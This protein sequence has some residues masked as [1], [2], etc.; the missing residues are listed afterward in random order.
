MRLDG[1][2]EERTRKPKS[3]WINPKYDSGSATTALAKMF[4]EKVF[5]NPK[6][7]AFLQDIF[8]ISTTSN[9]TILD[10]F[11]GSGS[12]GEAVLRLNEQDGGNRKFILVTNNEEKIC[13]DVTY[14]RLKKVIK[15]YKD[16]QDIKVDGVE[17]NLHHLKTEFINKKKYCYFICF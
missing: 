13:E 14:P 1:E 15:G 12:T 17:A 5:D 4:G 6:P 9:S 11:A 8:T 2:D 10:F 16:A 7:I 3:L